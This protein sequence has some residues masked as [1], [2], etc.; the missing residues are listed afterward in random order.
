[1][2]RKILSVSMAFVICFCLCGCDFFAS[3]T[4][5][6]LSPPALSGDLVPIAKAI[7]ESVDTTY[8]FEY[9]SRGDYR[10]AVVREDINGDGLL[11]AFAFYSIT[12][13]ETVTMNLNFVCLMDS[14]WESVAQQKLIAG[15]V[16]RIDF[17]DL[18]NDGISEMLVGWEIYGTSEMQLAVYSLVDN[19]LTQR[20]LKRYTHFTTCD[21]D[22]D[23][24]HEVLLINANTA[25]GIN[26]AALYEL[27]D[28]GITEHSVCELDSA[29]KTI[30]APVSAPLSS[31][32]PAIYID[33]IKGVGAV[34]EVLFIE[35]DRLVNPLF[36]PDSRETLATLR[37]AS[38]TTTDM[39]ADGI[40]EIPVQRDVPSVTRSQLNEKLYL[41][42]WC[43]FNGVTL[44]PQKN[45]MINVND[46][47]YFEIPSKWTNN[48][49]ILKDTDNRIREIYRYSTD[50][51]IVAESLLYIRAIKKS[52]WDSGEYESEN[53]E[54]ITSDGNTVFACRISHT[55]SKDGMTLESVKSAFKI[56]EQE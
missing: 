6:L 55:A 50:E 18:D 4:A 37:S 20:M 29:A 12:D 49:A 26:T 56:F 24:K 45:T 23:G 17:C 8:T 21:L 22:E 28:D 39:N 46:G 9:P 10:S 54:E 1:M 35:K 41:T 7:E 25:E 51:K 32:K 31:G 14:H 36:Q 5:E 11:E 27:T 48:I 15:G 13:R 2:L 53:L 16:D 44:T 30:N 3:D 42:E 43:S 19:T 34:T 52:D 38:F 40:P 47:Y 33:E